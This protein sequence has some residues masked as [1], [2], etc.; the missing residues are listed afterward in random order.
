MEGNCAT[1]ER[2]NYRRGRLVTYLKANTHTKYPGHHPSVGMSDNHP[3]WLYSSPGAL[4]DDS[5]PEKDEQFMV[6]DHKD[7]LRGGHWEGLK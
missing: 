1:L 5:P 3:I 2:H 6:L 7:E 4:I